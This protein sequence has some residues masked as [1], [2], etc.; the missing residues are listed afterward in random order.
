MYRAYL[1]P[2][3]TQYQ[4]RSAMYQAKLLLWDP[5][6]ESDAY[7][8]IGPKLKNELNKAEGF[9]FTVLPSN[10]RYDQIHKKKSVV[11][12]YDDDEWISE[13][14]VSDCPKDF[15]KQMKVTC[16][17]P[18]AYLCDSVQAPD[19]KNEVVIPTSSGNK[20]VRVPTRWYN[21]ANPHNEG[22]QERS[23]N[24]NSDGKYTYTLTRD[25]I[26]QSNKVYYYVSSGDNM[27]HSGST[28]IKRAATKETIANHLNRI[29]EVHNSQV[30]P[31]KK[32]Y[33]GYCV[34]DTTEHEFK[35]S[36][37]RETWSAI[38]SD[39]IEQYGRY[40]TVR[41][42][43]NYVL[44]LNYLELHDMD[45]HTTPEAKIEFTDNMIEMSESDDS[46]DD[47]FTVLVPVGKN[48]L[49]ISELS[50]HTSP[51]HNDNR[52]VNP[53]A[54]SGGNWGGNRRYIV[55]S[56]YAVDQYGYIV[57]TQTFSDADTAD[58]LWTS[59]VKYIKNNFDT[60]TEYEVKGI[61]KHIL[62][63]QNSRIVV[64]K[65]CRVKSGWHG[66]DEKDLYVISAE[67]DLVSP[68]NDTY[69]IGVPT[70]DR[71]AM[72]KTLTGQTTSAAT[73]SR[74]SAAGAAAGIQTVSSW[75]ENYFSEN[76]GWLELHNK[77]RNQVESEN[78]MFLTRFEQDEEHINMVAQKIFGVAGSDD[79]D[80]Q[81]AG[82]ILIPKPPYRRTGNGVEDYYESSDTSNT[83]YKV[84]NEHNWYVKG[85]DGKYSLSTQD[86]R[87]TQ[88][89]VDD[90]NV[91]FYIMRLAT[92]YSDVDVGPGGIKATV[93]GNYERSTYCSSWIQ[94]NEDEILA[95]TG[96][97]YVDEDGHV[98]VTSGSGM[99]TDHTQEDTITKY[100]QVARTMYKNGVN[101]ST[102]K[103]YE[104]KL[105]GP[106]GTWPGLGQ[107]DQ[108]TNAAYYK[109]TTDTTVDRNKYYYYKSGVREE[110]LAEY[111]VYDE[112]NL[113]A[114][115]M[116]RV[117]NNPTYHKVSIVDVNNA[118]IR[119]ES[120][121]AKGWYE[122]DETR[123]VY[124]LTL[125]TT[126]TS[127]TKAYYYVINNSQTWTDLRGDHIV[128]GP[129]EGTVDPGVM[130][131]AQQ[132]IQ[133]KNLNGTITEIA[134]DVVVVNTLLAK[135]IEA[136]EI[137]A[138]TSLWTD[139]LSFNDGNVMGTLTFW[140]TSGYMSEGTTIDEDMIE[141]NNVS[142]GA[143][144]IASASGE[145]IVFGAYSTLASE[146]GSEDPADIVLD[147]GT[148]TY[149]GDDVTIPY[150]NAGMSNFDT[151]HVITFTKPASL[152]SVT[153]SSGTKVLTAKTVGGK[154]F[155]VGEI[156]AYVPS[157]SSEAAAMSSAG[158]LA[159]ETTGYSTVYGI[160]YTY[161]NALNEDKNGKCMLFKTPRNRYP[162]AIS[163]VRTRSSSGVVDNGEISLGVNGV[164]TIYAQ[165]K[166][167]ANFDSGSNTYVSL[168]GIK[169]YAPAV[170]IAATVGSKNYKD[171]DTI[172]LGFGDSVSV[173]TQTKRHDQTDY[174]NYQQITVTSPTKPAA[175]GATE[176]KKGST[177]YHDGDS[178]TLGYSD[179]V[180]VYGK[181][182][183][184]DT[185]TYTNCSGITVKSPADNSTDH[186]ISLTAVGYQQNDPGSAYTNLT[187][188]KSHIEGAQADANRKWVYF[189][190][191]CGSAT[192]Y[193]K[194]KM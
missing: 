81:D 101:P 146:N 37:F 24:V 193:Y 167:E 179:S 176:A 17:G 186:D 30:D 143:I 48:S 188:L 147:F 159:T 127:T 106:G 79:V 46:D 133:D 19:E 180:K 155:L 175:N 169:S 103:W 12:I 170:K 73:S 25:T 144:M 158:Y 32:I 164:S 86:T 26:P 171:G 33:L 85:S 118:K 109:L 77:F 23:D 74:N 96:H 93:D 194:M 11:I 166:T 125:D 41:M 98:H 187:V 61:D 139:Q 87:V 174:I 172:A 92:R 173:K 140:T 59:A 119:N 113:T 107:A 1:V 102:K 148:V 181:F 141:V 182:K 134:S 152:G 120:P 100:I 57:K 163:T 49:T 63:P 82:W 99:R 130:A 78:G 83:A 128:V 21:N 157:G 124:G 9:E 4:N 34:E 145:D 161:K 88:A 45:P 135:Y 53:Y 62:D 20:Y 91:N 40:I 151:D 185:S 27:N 70:S 131:K 105:D 110:F 156:K 191:T 8:V 60:H 22:W 71:E 162:D 189:Y 80:N 58:K 56:N 38:K 89:Q 6:S 116:A 13:G 183:L 117:V 115:V 95:L 55:V 112:D 7:A 94:M 123:G 3:A 138:N 15:F 132:Y 35:S 126:V 136:D 14:V 18:L 69:K 44:K 43:D 50:G 184:S 165:Y 97:I 75:L 129:A 52:L 76:E 178:I 104:R 160:Y 168:T 47:I 192:K 16:S 153:W 10:I 84:P 154:D 177:T 90:P 142:C 51:E 121:R 2:D 29:L 150:R 72:N 5:H 114:G 39:I 28:I 149:S 122:Y 54:P 42:D 31:F 137:T 68:D 66:V 64:G 36:N 108:E 190:V 65:K 111:G 67:F